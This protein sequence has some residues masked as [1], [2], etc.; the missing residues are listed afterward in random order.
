MFMSPSENSGKML[1]SHVIQSL[2]NI[3]ATDSDGV[4]KF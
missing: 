2:S 3:I 4:Y 1:C